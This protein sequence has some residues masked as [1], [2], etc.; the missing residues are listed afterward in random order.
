MHSV[1]SW[2]VI[3]TCTPP[4]QVP[5]AAWTAKKPRTSDRMSSNRRVFTLF[6]TVMVLPC[7]GPLHRAHQR[8]QPHGDLVGAHAADQGHPPGHV[9]GI[10][11][12][13]DAQQIVRFQRRA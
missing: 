6:E 11:R 5:S 13:E 7:I 9:A 8:R 12:V 2:P 10:E 4:A 1:T 3:S